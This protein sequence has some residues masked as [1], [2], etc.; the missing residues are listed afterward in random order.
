MHIFPLLDQYAHVNILILIADDEFAGL[1]MEISLGGLVLV[2]EGIDITPKVEVLGVDKDWVW[3]IKQIK[4][5]HFS[6]EE[7]KDPFMNLID[8]KHDL[9]THYQGRNETLA[10][11]YTKFKN[12]V[13]VIEHQGG[14]I[15]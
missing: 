12:R 2:G 6:F 10:D 1:L 13:E 9:Q 3:L 5:L 7:K 15:G 4:L 14:S 11:F 8:A